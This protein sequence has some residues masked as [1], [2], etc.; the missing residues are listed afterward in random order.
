MNLDVNVFEGMAVTGLPA[1][2]L[3]QGEVVWQNGQLKVERGAGRCVRRPTHHPA[4]A[5]T[6]LLNRARRPKPVNRRVSLQQTP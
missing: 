5:S 2:T 1:V 6:E 4:F 3:S